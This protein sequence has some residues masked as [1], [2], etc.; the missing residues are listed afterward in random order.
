MIVAVSISFA[1]IGIASYWYFSNWKRAIAID[2][3]VL[4]GEQHCDNC[5]DI[6]YMCPICGCQFK[7]QFEADVCRDYCIILG[8]DRPH[9]HRGIHEHENFEE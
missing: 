5:D 3:N 4:K 2:R 8:R 9:E 1:L 6:Y 7:T